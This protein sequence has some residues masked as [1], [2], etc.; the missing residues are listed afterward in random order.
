M[1]DRL[2]LTFVTQD[3]LYLMDQYV[4]MSREGHPAARARPASSGLFS[5]YAS[6]M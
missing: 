4:L 3:L 5:R 1:R 2:P 6:A